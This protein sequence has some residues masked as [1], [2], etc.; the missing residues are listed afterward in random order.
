MPKI[1]ESRRAEIRSRILDA[2]QPLVAQHGVQGTSMNAIVRASGL[3][4][5]AIYG[6]FSSKAELVLALQDR[7]LDARVSAVALQ[8]QSSGSADDRLLELLHAQLGSILSSDRE[9]SRLNLQFT[10]SALQSPSSRA[11]VDVRYERMHALFG[12]LLREGMTS[13]GFRAD[14]DTDA[15]ATAILGLLDGLAV[16]WAFTSGSRFDWK[17]VLHAIEALLS[18][19]LRNAGTASPSGALG[20][21][22][23]G[24]QTNRSSRPRFASPSGS[25]P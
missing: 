9:R 6:H 23:K 8:F 20:V 4:K 15:T 25:G 3:S 22:R 21:H 2:A 16:D 7:T 19:G 12:D 18:R 1:T 13:G 5:G 14:L 17:R 11:Q 10:A 24:R